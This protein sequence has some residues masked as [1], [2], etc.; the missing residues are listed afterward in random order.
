MTTP[1][2]KS[3]DEL[4]KWLQPTE[5]L[6]PGNELKKHLSS[7]VPGTGDWLR[8]HEE[9]CEWKDG[10]RGCLWIKGL[11]GSGKS[12][13]AASTIT[14]LAENS[15][16]ELSR[17]PILYFFFRQIVERNHDPK[18]LVRDWAS[19][20]LPYS[21]TLQQDL[22]ILSA[23]DV[24]DNVDVSSM[25][26]IILTALKAVNKVYCVA[27]ALDEM[28]DQHASFIQKLKELGSLRPDTIKVLLTSRPIPKIE[29]LLR[30]TTTS[31]LRLE[32]SHLYPDIE[33]FVKTH[34]L[35]L[36]PS[37]SLEKDKLVREAICGRSNGLFLYARLTMD[38]LIEGLR[39]KTINEHELPTSLAELP[40]NLKDL[41]TRMLAEHSIRSDTSQDQ[42]LTIIQCVTQSARPLRVI[43]LGSI[44][45]LLKGDANYNLSDGKRLVKAA[46]GRLLEILED[47]SVSV[48]HHSFTEFV[49]D[50]SR[51][52]DVG[53]FP[54]LEEHEAHKLMVQVC[55]SY[56][57]ACDLPD[58]ITIPA[59][60]E[61]D[62][63]YDS[64]VYAETHPR[65]LFDRYDTQAGRSEAEGIKRAAVQQLRYK[66]PL[67]DYATENLIYHIKR[68]DSTDSNLHCILEQYLFSGS[69][70]LEI[71]LLMRW[72]N[73][74]RWDV[75]EL[76]VASN[77][78][79]TQYAQW[80]VATG[81]AVDVEDGEG[82]TPLMYAVSTF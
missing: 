19:Q 31:V 50:S 56:L 64:Y 21:T 81:A 15:Q 82:Y 35:L 17:T 20:L 47:E 3:I 71:W 61:G 79:L 68:S 1:K 46:C 48:I 32:T 34:L 53:G 54:V 36:E 41:Y 57:D 60:F 5:Y 78:G 42:Q 37:L 66:H 8:Q 80:L 12:V 13:F 11:P 10:D 49:R 72:G 73:Y 28:D 75:H 38:S 30:D 43:E 25:W 29:D 76:H 63:A 2:I 9:F 27:D 18:Y 45:A 67:L 24:I 58:N 40:L 44:I 33:Q 70:A 6:S 62:E 65:V 4:R 74:R 51:T 7:Y 55:L 59:S 26:A 39:N 52:A 77:S 14:K 69:T 22:S 23:E 16:P